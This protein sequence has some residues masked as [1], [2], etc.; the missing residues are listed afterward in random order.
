MS[1]YEDIKHKMLYAVILFDL[2]ENHPRDISNA[3]YSLMKYKEKQE[4]YEECH[5]IKKAIEHYKKI[6]K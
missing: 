5:V 6:I 2:L 1:T 3:Y 4:E